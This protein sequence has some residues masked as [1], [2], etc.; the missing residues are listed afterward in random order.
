MTTYV[1]LGKQAFEYFLL[2]CLDQS[3][4]HASERRFRQFSLRDVLHKG[5]NEWGFSIPV[6]QQRHIQISP[7]LTPIFSHIAL[8]QRV[9]VDG[10]RTELL[11]EGPVVFGIFGIGKFG[12]MH[13]AQLVLPVS[14]HGA[15]HWVG[16]QEF[17][18]EIFHCDS[19]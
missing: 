1:E 17:A 15:K 10:T 7:K 4:A 16:K 8:F 6:S 12:T 18:L 13:A 9:P 3:A 14:Q 11:K 5:K 2:L 19:Q